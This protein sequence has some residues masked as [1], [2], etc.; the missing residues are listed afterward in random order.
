ME[1]S[2]FAFGVCFKEEGSLGGLRFKGSGK[3]CQVCLP[4]IRKGSDL[5][6]LECSFQ[7]V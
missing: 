1:G 4:G 5:M 2:A 7:K 6:V 3:H